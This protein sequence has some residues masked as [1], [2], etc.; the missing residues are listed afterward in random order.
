MNKCGKFV[1][2]L[3]NE[4]LLNYIGLSVTLGVKFA[5]LLGS[6]VIRLVILG[7]VLIIE[8]VG[9][10]LTLLALK[11]TTKPFEYLGEKVIWGGLVPYKETKDG[12]TKKLVRDFIFKFIGGGIFYNA[13]YKF[14]ALRWVPYLKKINPFRKDKDKDQEPYEFT[15]P[16]FGEDK[17]PL[18]SSSVTGNEVSSTGPSITPFSSETGI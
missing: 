11:G 8:V 15:N 5:V 12:L 9:V 2:S 14:F 17:P 10:D 16:L 7:L 13:L 18:L 3:I 4:N 1:G 6:I